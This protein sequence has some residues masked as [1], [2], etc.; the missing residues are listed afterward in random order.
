M[1]K[2]FWSKVNEVLNSNFGLWFLSSVFLSGG[3]TAYQITEHHYQQKIAT[4]KELLT[5]EFEIANRLSSMKFL[6]QKAKTYGDAQ[7]ALTPVTKS[8]GAVSTEYENVNIAVLYYKTYLLTGIMHQQIGEYVRELE[9][10]NL[11]VQAQNPKTLFS[12]EDRKKLLA[13][14]DILQKHDVEVINSYKL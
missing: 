11:S 14:I 8:F 12:T 7:T 2:S 6:L 5:C 13:L 3:A 10:L 1:E 9:Q 4:Q